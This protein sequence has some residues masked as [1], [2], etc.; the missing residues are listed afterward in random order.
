MIARSGRPV[1]IL[2]TGLRPGEKLNEALFGRGETVMPT[3]HARLNRTPAP[4]V[5]AAEAAAI[6]LS[7]KPEKITASLRELATRAKTS[8]VDSSELPLGK[9]SSEAYN[10]Y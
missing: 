2:Y 8:P 6:D 10:V 1:R 9:R 5:D 7:A 4:H 3:S